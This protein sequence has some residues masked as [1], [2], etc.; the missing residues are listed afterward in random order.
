MVARGGKGEMQAA[1][2]GGRPVLAGLPEPRREESARSSAE[3]AATYIRRLIFERS[4]PAGSRIPQDEIAEKLG[5]TRMPVREAL[6]ILRHE[7]RIRIEKNRGAFVVSISEQSARDACELTSR[8]H[9]FA[10]ERALERSDRAFFDRL[11]GLNEQLQAADD[12]VD[13]YHRWDDFLDLIAT[14]GIG[15][16]LASFLRDM[17]RLGPDTL[18]EQAPELA[19]IIKS[20]AGRIVGGFEGHDLDAVLSSGHRCFNAIIDHLAP[21]L[22]N[23]GV[24]ES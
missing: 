6:L 14:F 24:I 1:A 23:V 8:M 22:R 16:R 17:R 11:V 3:H 15:D 9:G 10:F 19:P 12:L 7:G 2:G 4:L 13:F 5:M 20:G 21:S 18:Y